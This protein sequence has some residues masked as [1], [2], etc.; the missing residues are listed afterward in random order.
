MKNKYLIIAGALALSLASCQQEA[1]QV[2]DSKVSYSLV[3]IEPLEERSFKHE[4]AVQGN[5][6]TDQDVLLTAE[7]G[8]LITQVLVKE[9]Q[10]V[11]KGQL[12]AQVDASVLSSNVQELQTQLEYAQYMLE[13]QEELKKRGVGS[14]IDLETAKNRVS[15]L[16]ASINSLNTQRGKANIKAPFSGTIDQVFAKKGQMAGP[17]SPIARLVNNSVV[18]ITAGISEKHFA[19]IKVG[20]PI[21]VS[22]PNYA[23]TIVNLEIT[24]VGNYIE[25]TNRTFRIM[26]SIKNNDFFLPNMLAEIRITDMEV[27]SGKVIPTKSILKDQ[28]NRD[29][30][31]V[32]EPYTGEKNNE[33]LFVAKKKVIRVIESYNGAS[34]IESN[35]LKA[36]SKVIVEGAKGIGNKDIVRIK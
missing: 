18:D 29:F 3:T 34:L 28:E 2:E 23:D 35:E 6:E 5:V 1:E 25:P 32:A 27:E 19:K 20:T 15:S 8:G 14:E 26:S 10:K 12:I 16:E 11:S 24:N 36:G 31:F 7:M 22:F 33:K 21:K 30:I 17:S 9:G 13:K 4:I